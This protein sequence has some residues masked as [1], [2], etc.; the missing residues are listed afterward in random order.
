VIRR[1]AIVHGRVQ[2]VGFRYAAREHAH[3]LGLTGL[4]R[5]RS[6]GTV[7]AEFQ[8]AVAAVEQI[9]DWLHQGPPDAHV[10]AVDVEDRPTADEHDFRIA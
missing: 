3:A 1:R 2:G 4:V 6:D 5:N 9:L 8:G 10:S 7:E